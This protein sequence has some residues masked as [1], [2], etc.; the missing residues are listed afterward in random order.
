MAIAPRAAFQRRDA[1]F[2]HRDGGIGNTRIDMPRAL[3]VKQRRGMIGIFEHKRRA[4]INR[5][6]PRAG[7][8]IG[9]RTRVQA[10]GIK[11]EI[12]GPTHG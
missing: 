12:L 6:R 8:G 1:L 3:H 5:R 7:G 2:Q 4:L 9:L 10:Q 11:A